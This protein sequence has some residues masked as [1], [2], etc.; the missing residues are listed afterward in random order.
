MTMK[1]RWTEVDERAFA[2]LMRVAH[3]ERMPAIRLYRRCSSHLEKALAIAMR[4]A[5]TDNEI[6]RRKACAEACRQRAL[7]LRQ[8]LTSERGSKSAARAVSVIANA[9]VGG[10]ERI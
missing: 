9:I 6:V 8:Q 1:T 7:R 5:P 2:Q 3:L 10:T 4:E